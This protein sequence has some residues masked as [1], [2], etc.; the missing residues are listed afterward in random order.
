MITS[1][2]TEIFKP[3]EF[4]DIYN[5]NNVGVIL[6]N[7]LD[8]KN[9][10]H[11]LFYGNSG[12]GKTSS[13]KIFIK[14]FYGSMS[15][16]N[17]LYLN[18]SDDRGINV[19]REKIKT[20]SKLITSKHNL[21]II[22]LDEADNMTNDAQSALRRIMEIYSK[23]TRFI[24]VCNYINKIIDPIV[25]RCCKIKFNPLSDDQ[26]LKII[27]NVE[28]KM[29]ITIK[30]QIVNYIIAETKGDARKTLNIL[31]SLYAIHYSNSDKLD[32]IRILD[33]LTGNV[34]A[35]IFET[36]VHNIEKS[37][38]NELSKLL[39]DFIYENYDTNKIVKK[40]IK[41]IFETDFSDKIKN[42]L[43]SDLNNLLKRIF[44]GVPEEFVLRT[45]VYKYKYAYN[46]HIQ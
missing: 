38:S 32:I 31:E 36:F 40:F 1:S 11:L 8:E 12:N 19:V 24:I 33:D 17:V 22:V 34:S 9:I 29:G 35:K 43:I 2:F 28:N 27:H 3:T 10:P 20:F 5:N 26:I 45:V 42:K 21:K 41:Y 14:K 37:D 7:Y 13:V 23:N 46:N 6:Q 18:A 4:V 25:S 30:K 39:N 15:H 44:D 16:P